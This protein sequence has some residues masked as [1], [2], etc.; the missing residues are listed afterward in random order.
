MTAPTRSLSAEERTEVARLI[1][2]GGLIAAVAFIRRATG[3]TLAEAVVAA[4]AAGVELGAITPPRPGH[5][6]TAEILAIGPFSAAIAP[7][8][9]YS[10]ERYEGVPEGTPVIATIIDTYRDTEQTF[11]LAACFGVDPWDFNAHAPLDPARVDL[12]AL[13]ALDDAAREPFE[14]LR[15][16]G[17]V[18]YFYGPLSDDA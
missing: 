9:P 5:P 6:L 14:R 1:A 2:D 15:D 7:F 17:F 8:L 4:R 3:A 11:E 12:E 16:A 13:G 18:F 10:S